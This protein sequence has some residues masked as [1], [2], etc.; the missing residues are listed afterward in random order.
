MA[1]L[2]QNFRQMWNGQDKLATA[3]VWKDGTNR[4]RSVITPPLSIKPDDPLAAYFLNAPGAAEIEKL[5]LDSPVL[6][7]L[8]ESGVKLVVPMINQGQL[9]GLINLGLRMS[10]QDYSTDDRGLLN[11][12]ATQAAPAVRVAQLV[13]EQHMLAREREQMEQEMRIAR[14][15]QQTLLPKD[16]PALPGWQLSAY[17]QPARAVGGDFYDFLSFEDG[18]LGIVIGDVTDKGVPAALLMATTRSI[19]RS[20]AQTETS[21]GKVLEQANNLLCPDMPAKMFVTCLYA[22]LDPSTGRLRYANAGH[23][24]PYQRHNECVSELW[25]RGMPLGI[26]PDMCYEE[27]ETRLDRGES[28]LFYSDGLVEAHN[29]RREMFGFPRLQALLGE[30]LGDKTIIDFLLGELAAFTGSGWEQEDDVTLVTLQ[31]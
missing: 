5:H 18:R 26:M 30:H 10:E 22:I 20:V 15:I 19:V 7:A 13:R 29:T 24:Q 14:L 21:P 4:P 28:V 1:R 31:R 17:Y 27:R 6:Q 25:A 2:M 8:K 23:D 11:T 16:L 3:A 9:V 12:L